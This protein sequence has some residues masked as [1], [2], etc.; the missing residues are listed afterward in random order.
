M[1]LPVDC[2][3]QQAFVIH[4][5]ATSEINEGKEADYTDTVRVYFVTVM[6][7]SSNAKCTAC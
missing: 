4:Y 1:G 5:F 3:E 6:L 2:A 7:Q